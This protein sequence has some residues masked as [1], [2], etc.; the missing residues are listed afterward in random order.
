M[1]A[2]RANPD[3]RAQTERIRI[4]DGSDKNTCLLAFVVSRR[5]A[6]RLCNEP[7]PAG[8]DEQMDKIYTI[9][10]DGSHR[11]LHRH[12]RN[13]ARVVTGWANDRLPDTLRHPPRHSGGKDVTSALNSCGAIGESAPPVWS[14]DGTTLAFETTSGVY[15]MNANGSD[16]HRVSRK[17]RG[18][19]TRSPGRPSWRPVPPGASSFA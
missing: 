7:P 9:A 8:R 15:V 11:R 3:Q 1:S 17:R 5:H 2:T 6:A 14:P 18:P 12:R 19:G 4:R 13:R 16:L 10:L